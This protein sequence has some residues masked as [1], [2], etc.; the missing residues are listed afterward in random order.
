MIIKKI[1]QA[2]KTKAKQD[3]LEEYPDVAEA[4]KNARIDKYGLRKSTFDIDEGP[5]ELLPRR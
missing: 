2:Y 5:K 1:F 3:M 4:V